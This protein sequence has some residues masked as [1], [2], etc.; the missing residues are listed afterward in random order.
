MGISPRLQVLPRADS[1]HALEG[2][3]Q[4]ELTH[5]RLRRKFCQFY[6]LIFPRGIEQTTDTLREHDLRIH[7]RVDARFT[8]QAG[9]KTS[10]FSGVRHIEKRNSIASRAARW[11]RRAAVNFR[12]TNRENELPIKAGVPRYNGLP[13]LIFHNGKDHKTQMKSDLSASCA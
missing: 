7:C 4:M 8:A 1:H 9:P 12:R 2:A 6:C 5:S 13:E 3:L 10:L 11:A